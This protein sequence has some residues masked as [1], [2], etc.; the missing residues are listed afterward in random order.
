M[1]VFED[2]KDID[3]LDDEDFD[4]E[5]MSTWNDAGEVFVV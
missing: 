3:N 2:N 1:D 4:P 5:S